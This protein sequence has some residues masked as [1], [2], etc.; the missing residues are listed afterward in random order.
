M[1]TPSRACISKVAK[2]SGNPCARSVMWIINTP[3]P[4]SLQ[5]KLG[6]GVPQIFTIS[7]T[8]YATIV[9]VFKEIGS[10]FTSKTNQEIFFSE[11]K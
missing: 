8:F 11:K 4:C 9:Q 1:T 5:S 7:E 2:I 3:M 10:T 6:S